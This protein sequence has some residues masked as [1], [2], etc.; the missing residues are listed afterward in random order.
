[1]TE[2][3]LTASM[4]ADALGCFWNAAIGEAH[5]RGGYDAMTFAA[6]MATGMQAI[7]ARLREHATSNVTEETQ[8]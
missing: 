8:T 6:I 1:M 7:E 2:K 5:N 4:L 3:P